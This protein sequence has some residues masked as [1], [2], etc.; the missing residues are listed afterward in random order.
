MATCSQYKER[1]ADGWKKISDALSLEL[2]TMFRGL[3]AQE[4]TS[5]AQHVQ[6]TSPVTHVPVLIC[7]CLKRNSFFKSLQVCVHIKNSKQESL[8]S[9]CNQTLNVFLL[10]KF[11]GFFKQ[12][13]TVS[14]TR[15]CIFCIRMV[16]V[17]KDNLF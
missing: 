9:C 15:L 10:D 2:T 3:P 16:V 17:S 6:H 14:N 12:D 4:C 7:I 13:H 11:L 8:E 1:N 5:R